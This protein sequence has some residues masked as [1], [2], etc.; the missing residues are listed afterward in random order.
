MKRKLY[1]VLYCAANGL[2][3]KKG[4][5]KIVV[6]REM[7]ANAN[8][9]LI[10]YCGNN[11]ISS[12]EITGSGAYLINGVYVESFVHGNDDSD[13]ILLASEL[14]KKANLVSRN[15]NLSVS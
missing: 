15:L 1:E 10:R 12:L 7:L 9:F 11:S 8:D 14:E 3:V 6:N 5:K 4:I 2:E 13:Y